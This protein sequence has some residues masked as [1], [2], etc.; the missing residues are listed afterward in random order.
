[1]ST[2]YW[3]THG[4][5]DGEV[6]LMCSGLGG[7]AGYWAPQ[8]PAL[9]EA[10]YRV[11]LYD[12]RG[13]GR[14]LQPLKA[15][16]RIEDMAADVL[17]LLEQAGARQCHFVGHAL[18]GLVGLQLALDAPAAL[19]SL[20]LINAW[21]QPNPH[22]ARC[23]EARL[24]LLDHAGP[25]AYVQAQPIF[26]YPASWAALHAERVDQEVEHA[27]EHFPGAATLRARIGALRRFDVSDRLAQVIT[28]TLVSVALDDVLVPATCSAQLARAI[29][30]SV[31]HAVPHGAHAHNI[32]DAPA[33]NRA[34]LS[35]L[36]RLR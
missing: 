8:V 27:L 22:S 1:M 32:T 13:T 10:G 7:S 9:V 14:S 5:A 30:G 31:Y 19:A 17:A 15:D 24:A 28:P 18:G 23:F 12:Q 6:V 26:L 25:R 20:A 16:Y 3:E 33:F 2:L 21:A 34:L 29:A 36:A 35:F 4:P 11:V